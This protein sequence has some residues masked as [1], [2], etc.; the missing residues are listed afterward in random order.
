MPE[1][2]IIDKSFSLSRKRGNGTVRYEVWEI[3]GAVSRYN[4]AYI[5]HRIYF[6]DNGRVLGYD[7]RHGHHRHYMGVVESVDTDCYEEIEQRF[8]QEWVVLLEA[9]NAKHNR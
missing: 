6:G 3:D 8:E 9:Y 1:I 7:N 4:L 5:N 2:K